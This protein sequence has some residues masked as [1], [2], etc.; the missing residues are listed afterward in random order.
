MCPWS[1]SGTL[2]E[3]DRILMSVLSFVF[4]FS[5]PRLA[6]HVGLSLSDKPLT[7]TISQSQS[8]GR[9]ACIKM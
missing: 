8:V 3:S 5:R 1:N 6:A 4:P 7:F 9:H 2:S